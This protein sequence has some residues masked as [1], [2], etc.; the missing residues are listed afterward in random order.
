MKKLYKEFKRLLEDRSEYKKMSN[1]SNP[2]GDGD[3]CKKIV[4][5]L[6]SKLKV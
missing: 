1:A 5:I 2:Y 4:N 3:A 6:E